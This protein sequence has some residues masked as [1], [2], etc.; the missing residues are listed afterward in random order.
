MTKPFKPTIIQ[1]KDRGASGPTVRFSFKFNA[2]TGDTMEG[3]QIRRRK[4]FPVVGNNEYWNG[5]I[6]SSVTTSFASPGATVVDGQTF[7]VDIGTTTLVNEVYEWTVRTRDTATQSISDD[8]PLRILVVHAVPANITA[9]ASST[10]ETR[11]QII[12]NATYGSGRRQKAYRWAVYHPDVYNLAGFDPSLDVW[13]ELS[14]WIM[15]DYGYSSVVNRVRVEADL[16][17]GVAYRMYGILVDDLDLS[18]AWVLGGTFSTSFTLQAQPAVAV[19]PQPHLG[20]VSITASSGFNLLG[21]QTA[22]FDSGIGTWKVSAN[23]RVSYNSNATF[24]KEGLGSMLVEVSGSTYG[25]LD[26]AHTTYSAQDT[27]FTTYANMSSGFDAGAGGTVV[28]SGTTNSESA[29]VAPNNVHSS[30]ISVRPSNAT[31]SV[32]CRIRWYKSDGTAATTAFTAGS[33]TSCPAG[34]WTNVTVQNATSP[35]DA[36]YARLEVIISTATE[37]DRIYLDNAAI[38]RSA[39]VEWSLGGA[40]VDV[41]FIIQR[42]LD[43]G[44]TWTYLWGNDHEHPYPPDSSTV[45]EGIYYDRGAPV[46]GGGKIIYR[47]IAV[48]N[49]STRPLHSAPVDTLIDEL[50][51]Q[52]WWLRSYDRAIMDQQ[53]IAAKF[54]IDSTPPT[55][56]YSPENSKYPVVVSTT[57]PSVTTINVTVW[58]RD[59]FSYETITEMLRSADTLYLQRNIGDGFFFKCTGNINMEQRS[60]SGAGL[61]PNHVHVMTF[62][63]TVVGQPE[64]V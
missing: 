43:Y 45:F 36:A 61:T 5:S 54:T 1:P 47:V 48:S 12:W 41:G 2:L 14:A 49:K 23:G 10:G 35:A 30:V 26:T 39:A 27:A 3:Y 63:A 32:Q 9:T 24:V 31:E 37:G 18:S 40:S 42:S 17:N 16:E 28:V 11:P 13:Q 44:E 56:V 53:I 7:T 29:A 19:V 58:L 51:Y 25:F 38:A 60:S 62:N 20:R 55:Q 52:G 59:S 64:A 34:V 15:S 4:L 6:W 57:Q 50:E 46:G 8:L 33:V 21:S 22:N